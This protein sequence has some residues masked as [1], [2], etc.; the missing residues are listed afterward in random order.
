LEAIEV[1]TA[2]GETTVEISTNKPID[3]SD[4]SLKADITNILNGQIKDIQVNFNILARTRFELDGD[5]LVILPTKKIATNPIPGNQLDGSIENST[6]IKDRVEI[7]KEIPDLHKENVKMAIDNLQLVY[8]KV[9][10]IAKS[11][12]ED[13]TKIIS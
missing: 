8:E 3:G 13:D 10:D 9:L 12:V 2:I 1:V 5:L 4:I 7:D 11:L 6:E